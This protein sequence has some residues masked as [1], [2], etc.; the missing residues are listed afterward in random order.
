VVIPSGDLAPMRKHRR[1]GRRRSRWPA[2][3]VVLVMVAI[4]GATYAYSQRTDDSGSAPPPAACPSPSAA[5]PSP[6]AVAKAPAKA[7]AK[8]AAV[9]LPAP[10]QV[11]LRLLNG[12]GR[13]R[14]ARTVANEL[15]RRGFRVTHTGNAPRDLMGGSR[16][17]YGPGGRPAALLVSA[18]VLGSSV[19]PVPSAARGAIDV[20]LG[21][22]FVRLR[23]PAETSA[24]ARRLVTT[25]VPVP[26]P[27]TKPAPSPSCR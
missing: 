1:Y 25:G 24:Y 20:V 5:V 13:D 12:T 19:V 4:A 7:P 2:V 14:L 9:R 27:S 15:A 18:H 8:V 22:S 16:V 6:T 10:G 26:K 3:L 17:Y 21:S 23:T 11:A